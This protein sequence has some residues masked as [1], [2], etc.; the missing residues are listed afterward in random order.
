MSRWRLL[1]LCF[2]LAWLATGL[3][4]LVEVHQGESLVLQRLPVITAYLDPLVLW[5]FLLAHLLLSGLLAAVLWG[6]AVLVGGL[7]RR[8]REHQSA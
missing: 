1:G 5:P 4:P 7:V 8:R 3:P 6:L 2:V